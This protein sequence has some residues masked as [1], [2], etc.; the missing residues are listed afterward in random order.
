MG[1]RFQPRSILT[2]VFIVIF[3]Y[4]VYEVWDMPDQAKMYP[5]TIGLISLVLLVWQFV[6]EILPSKKENSFETGVDMDFT[7]EE[8]SREGK[9]RALE[10]FG[11]M[12]GFAAS[13]WLL[14]YFVA[15]PLMVFLY[16]VRHKESRVLTIA[17]PTAAGLA[18][19]MLFSHLL[20]LPFPPG[21][22]LELS[23]FD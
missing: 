15:I 18:T 9:R 3:T 14:G 5:W 8:A 21:L 7:E 16:M 17:M 11:W 12:Y 13:L 2:L 22:L 20:H 1:L 4:A 19:W 23:G 10:L 6:H